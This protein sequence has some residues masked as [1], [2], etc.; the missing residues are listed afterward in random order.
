MCR[1]RVEA[2]DGLA[3]RSENEDSRQIAF[4]ILTGL[5][6]NIDIQSNNTAGKGCSIML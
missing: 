2:G 1:Q 6:L 5:S 3:V 4:H